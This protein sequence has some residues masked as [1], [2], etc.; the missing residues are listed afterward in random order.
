[1][2]CI[3]RDRATRSNFYLFLCSLSTQTSSLFPTELR[4]SQNQDWAPINPRIA[5]SN[6]DLVAY[7]CGNDIFVH[8]AISGHSERLTFA[9]SSKRNDPLSAG[10]PSYVMQ[11]EFNRYE[12]FW[13]Q[14]CCEDDI[15]RICYEEVDESDVGIF[16]IPSSY[17]TYRCEEYRFPRAGTP[18]AKSTLKLVEFRLSEN[19][20]IVDVVNRELH[21]PLVYQFPY[22]EY[23]VR[24]GWTPDGSYVWTQLLDRQQQFLQL[25]LI[26][27]ESF[28]NEPYSSN[29]SSSMESISEK[30]MFEVMMTKS[31][32]P[33]Q[34]IYTERTSQWINVHNL[35]HFLEVRED[36]V[37]FIWSSEETGFRHLY[38]V[39]SSLR[40]NAAAVV[41][42]NGIRTHSAFCDE[43]VDDNMKARVIKKI[44]LTDGEWEVLIDKLWF[45][46][47][48][49]LLYFMGLEHSP[50]EKHLY[51]LNLSEP[52]RRRQ[53]TTPGSTN[54]IE[55]NDV[56]ANVLLSRNKQLLLI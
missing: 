46:R 52:G 29:P 49:N 7:V 42:K 32:K 45:D 36:C 24:V 28:C 38:Q 50:L 6:S 31:S 54:A 30:H 8:H 18:N 2:F 17:N 33:L 13:W 47:A 56:S 35:L 1:M 11:E 39:C 37:E 40:V 15:Y 14:P 10:V 4:L 23:I 5:P 27:F 22:L 20:R 3:Y 43:T 34:V 12:G 19:L 53:L 21:I 41:E 44:Q 51:V 48:K 26:P 55:F 16:T 9:H 25:V